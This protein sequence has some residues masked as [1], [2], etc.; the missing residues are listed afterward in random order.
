MNSRF[1]LLAVAAAVAI[2]M[3]Q[4]PGCQKMDEQ[5]YDSA[6]ELLKLR[7]YEEAEK[8]LTF[9][10]NQ[11]PESGFAAK[12]YFKLGELEYFFFKKPE[13]ALDNFVHAARADKKGKTGLEAQKHIAEIYLNHMR[14]HE[15]AILQYQRIIR[16]FKGMVEADKFHYLVAQAY[17]GKR[18]YKQAIIEYQ[19]LLDIFPESKRRE[20]VMYNIATCYFVDGQLEEA[21]AQYLAFLIKHNSSKHDYDARMSLAMVYEGLERPQKALSVYEYLA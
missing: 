10:V 16:D 19:N 3:L 12:A 4:G 8:K 6:E 20:E 9:L 13:A 2:I 5:L 11:Y 17:Y 21:M 7:K 1:A 18:D 15:L 14:N